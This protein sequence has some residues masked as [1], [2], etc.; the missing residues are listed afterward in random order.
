MSPEQGEVK[1]FVYAYKL[2]LPNLVNA[3]L[4]SPIVHS[5]IHIGTLGQDGKIVNTGK[6]TIVADNVSAK[7]GDRVVTYEP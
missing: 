6:T 5:R 3:F 2:N 1:P 4:D 7:P